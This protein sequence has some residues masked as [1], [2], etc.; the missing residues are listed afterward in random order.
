MG[1]LDVEGHLR[2]VMDMLSPHLD[3]ATSKLASFVNGTE[4]ESEPEE[5]LAEYLRW[6]EW[7]R[8]MG[9]TDEPIENEV[10]EIMGDEYA[11]TAF[12]GDAYHVGGGSGSSGYSGHADDGLGKRDKPGREKPDGSHKFPGV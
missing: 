12:S 5:R 4:K 9:Y 11:G 2:T 10:L 7:R 1:R 8:D 3:A 6:R